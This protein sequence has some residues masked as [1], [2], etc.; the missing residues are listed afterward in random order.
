M[1]FPFSVGA[2]V[3]AVA[4]QISVALV[5]TFD[6]SGLS[7]WMGS[8]YLIK[9][10]AALGEIE[11]GAADIAIVNQIPSEKSWPE[12]RDGFVPAMEKR[13]LA[14]RKRDPQTR[15]F[16]VLPAQASQEGF[17][18]REVNEELVPLLR[19]AADES[20]VK[21]IALEPAPGEGEQIAEAVVDFSAQK[22]HWRLVSADSEEPGEGPAANAIDGNPATYWH[23]RYS[24]KPDRYPHQLIVDMSEDTRIAGF[25]YVPR[26][27]GGTNGRIKS[28]RFFIS[29]DGSTWGTAVASGAFP[30]TN[31][32][33][34]VRFAIP[35]DARYFKFVALSEQS[36]QPYATAA[37][38]DVIPS[39]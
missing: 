9:D 24:P 28:Y 5:G 10:Y 11:P 29:A 6:E 36:G 3:H 12:M 21:T 37:E 32:P 15:L 33:T 18:D 13:L 22:T 34:L 17:N 7:R 38:I 1:I 39:P 14:F 35:V 4:T 8:G 27:D 30:N 31:K 20:G 26:Q 16:V 2:P 19:Q 23:T 25:R